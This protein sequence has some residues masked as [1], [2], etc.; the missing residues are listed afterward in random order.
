MTAAPA[1][2]LVDAVESK[3]LAGSAAAALGLVEPG[4]GPG[5]RRY[6]TLL[7]ALSDPADH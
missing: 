7:S 6:S 1:L 2:R 4:V 5:Q 3:S